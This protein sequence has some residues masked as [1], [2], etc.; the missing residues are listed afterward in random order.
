M[1]CDLCW[2]W[3]IIDFLLSMFQQLISSGWWSNSQSEGLSKN[4]PLRIPLQKRASIGC[5]GVFVIS[6]VFRQAFTT[7]FHISDSSQSSTLLCSIFLPFPTPFHFHLFLPFQFVLK[8]SAAVSTSRAAVDTKPGS[9]MLFPL[10]CWGLISRKGSLN[11]LLV[12]RHSFPM[13][14][15]VQMHY[16]WTWLEWCRTRLWSK[17]RHWR[18]P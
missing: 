13:P 5:M 10:S 8:E 6:F 7:F 2:I 1:F 4:I 14:V 3:Y 17:N 12:W 15:T 16:A 11:F 9:I 18:S